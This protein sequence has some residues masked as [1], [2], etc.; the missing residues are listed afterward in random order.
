MPFSPNTILITGY[1]LTGMLIVAGFMKMLRNNNTIKVITL[2]S[3]L[4]AAGGFL[5]RS[6][7]T[8]MTTGNAADSFFGP[9]IY[10]LS[11]SLLR[12]FYK[13]KYKVEPTYEKYSWFDH[14][15]RRPQN[16]LDVTVH[17]LPMMLSII[18]PLSIE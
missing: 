1:I 5:I 18:I 15:E 13:R 8:K 16:W 14:A 9:S 6:E 10:I 4:V 17:I 12:Y 3:I 7:T 11:Y 2:I